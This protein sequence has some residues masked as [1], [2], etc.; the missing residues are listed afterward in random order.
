MGWQQ[1][2]RF[3]ESFLVFCFV[4]FLFLGKLPFENPRRCIWMFTNSW[5]VRVGINCSD[6]GTQCIRVSR[7]C[8]KSLLQLHCT[9]DPF[10]WV[11]HIDS[12]YRGLSLSTAILVHL[13]SISFFLIWWSLIILILHLRLSLQCSYY[14]LTEL[15]SG[16][17]S[18]DDTSR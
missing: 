6:T 15:Q 11:A 5:M 12:K 4:Q 17:K 3:S 10:N 14:L 16:V 1:E 13:W 2:L 9:G 7:R 8:P 18:G